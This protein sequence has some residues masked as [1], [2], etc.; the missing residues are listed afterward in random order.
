MKNDD[1][2]KQ[3][4]S[5]LDPLAQRH[6]NKAVVMNNVLAKIE[7]KS[8]SRYSIWK[9]TGFAVAAAIMGVVVLPSALEINDKGFSQQVVISPKLSPQMVE[10][11]EML[12]VFAEDQVPHGS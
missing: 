11:L 5:R 8:S 6:R 3:L 10:D 4:A 1:Y 12:T 7:D 9:M 2:A